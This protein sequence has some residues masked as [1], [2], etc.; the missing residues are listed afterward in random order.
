VDG[1]LDLLNKVIPLNDQTKAMWKL[2]M[3]E[4]VVIDFEDIPE[5]FRTAKILSLWLWWDIGRMPN[6]PKEYWTPKLKSR[7]FKVV[8]KIISSAETE[9][10]LIGMMKVMNSIRIR[11]RIPDGKAI[12]PTPSPTV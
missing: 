11:D 12:I 4:G 9:E 6:I 8:K 1:W 3:E 2:M 10:E 5:R 7:V